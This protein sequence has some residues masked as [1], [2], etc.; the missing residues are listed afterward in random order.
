MRTDE[1]IANIAKLRRAEAEYE[2]ARQRFNDE[3][4]LRAVLAQEEAASAAEAQSFNQ[5]MDALSIKNSLDDIK[6]QL[7]MQDWRR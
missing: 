1:Q 6:F 3:M 2:A 4:K 5:Q 7:D